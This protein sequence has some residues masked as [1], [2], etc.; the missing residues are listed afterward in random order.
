MNTM[1]DVYQLSDQQLTHMRRQLDS[2]TELAD[3]S[4]KVMDIV[5]TNGIKRYMAIVTGY[6]DWFAICYSMKYGC[7]QAIGVSIPWIMSL[8]KNCGFSLLAKIIAK[9]LPD[10]KVRLESN[11]LTISK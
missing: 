7:V 2:N 6:Q 8:R 11:Y 1:P 10:F 5:I 4:S 3:Q 9:D